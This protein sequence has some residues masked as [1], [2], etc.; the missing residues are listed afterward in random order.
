[1]YVHISKYHLRTEALLFLLDVPVPTSVP[2]EVLKCYFF[3][4]FIEYI[5]SCVCIYQGTVTLLMFIHS[6]VHI[7]ILFHRILLLFLLFPL[8]LYLERCRRTPISI[9]EKPSTP[10]MVAIFQGSCVY[11]T[12]HTQAEIPRTLPFLARMV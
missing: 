4:L 1:M 6:T 10:V 5:F 12:R 9:L 8:P 3:F 11:A 2:D 7:V